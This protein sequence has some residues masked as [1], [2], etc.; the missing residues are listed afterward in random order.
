MT[1]NKWW[2]TH[3]P[4]C[5]ATETV[6]MLMQVHEDMIRYC[7]NCKFQWSTELPEQVLIML[8]AGHVRKEI[9]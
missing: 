6:E 5:G 1:A 9:K 2:E 8:A 4:I 3:C 7:R